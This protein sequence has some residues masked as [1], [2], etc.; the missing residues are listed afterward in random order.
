M[1]GTPETPQGAPRTGNSPISEPAPAPNP[2]GPPEALP[3]HLDPASNSFDPAA[4]LERWA[5]QMDIYTGPDAMLNFNRVDYVHIDLTAANPS[6][7]AQLLAGRKTRLSTILR[8]KSLLEEGMRAAR[9]L[10]T[11]IYELSTDHG[12]DSGYFVAG[13]ASWLS[14]STR[15]HTVSY[16]KRFIAPIL[17]APLSITPHPSSDDY[18]LRLAGAARLNPAMVRQI[19]QEYDIDLGTMDVAQLANSM[20]RLDPEPVIERMRATTGNIPG[21]AIESRFF[22]STFAD[23]KESMGELPHTAHTPL[24]R[25]IAA[26]KVPGVQPNI[27]PLVQ[28]QPPHD[29]RDPQRET[30][31]LDADPA[32]QTIIDAAASGNSFTVTA[33]PA[34]SRYAPP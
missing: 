9:T 6:G 25:D 5:E 21:M 32:A 23:L 1:N 16:E 22:I 31:L 11:K 29:D 20:S 15:E 4:G 33:A 27:R 17:M 10:R 13:T 2:D 30:Q 12:L 34:P 18:E 3:P 28:N 14:R 7:L 8:E 19:K 24:V 26:L